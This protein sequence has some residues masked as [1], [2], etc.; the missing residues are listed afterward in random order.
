MCALK[1]VHMV[2]KCVVHIA[3]FPGR[4][5]F[6]HLQYGVYDMMLQFPLI[7]LYSGLYAWLG[8]G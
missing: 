8:L 7:T 1:V 2:H 4:P 5:G 3:S 6:D